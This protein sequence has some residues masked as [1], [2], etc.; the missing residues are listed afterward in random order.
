MA[1][2]CTQPQG[3]GRR[4]VD[5]SIRDQIQGGVVR[6][7]GAATM[8]S[9]AVEGKWGLRVQLT[10]GMKGKEGTGDPGRPDRKSPGICP[11]AGSVR[12]EKQSFFADIPP[13]HGVL[14]Q[15][16]RKFSEH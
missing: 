14:L 2:G 6:G 9:D 7:V 3:L 1:A 4:P 12:P 16:Q 15:T 13:Q 11:E 5:E 8:V 10:Q